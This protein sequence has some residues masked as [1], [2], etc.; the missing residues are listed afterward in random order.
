VADTWHELWDRLDGGHG[1]VAASLPDCAA[2]LGAELPA[3]EAAARHVAPYVHADGSPRW[4]V[5]ELAD[6][7]GLA[8]RNTK[9]YRLGR[10]SGDRD[11]GRG[12]RHSRRGA[13]ATKARRAAERAAELAEPEPERVEDLAELVDL[14]G[15]GEDLAAEQ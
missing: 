6:R 14:D 13:A 8:D 11:G 4:S 1:P 2:L 9:G 15:A 7:L 12:R 10:R 5:A 3:V